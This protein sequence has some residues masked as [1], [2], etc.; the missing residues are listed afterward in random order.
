[1]TASDP[2]LEYLREK[3]SE[4][5]GQLEKVQAELKA[6]VDITLKDQYENR[7]DLL[8]K[9]I[10]KISQNI[11]SLERDHQD[12]SIKQEI[13]QLI[14][15]LQS[16]DSQWEIFQQSYHMTLLHWNSR[17]QRNVENVQSIISELSKIVQGEA[18]YNALEEFIAHLIHS[19]LDPVLVNALNQWGT[20][21]RPNIDWL[22]LYTQIQ[23][24]QDQRLEK[25]QP[26]ILMTI[27]R[28]DQ[29]STQA[30]DDETYYQLNAWLVEDIETYRSQKTGYYALLD[31]DS[32][33][34]KPCSLDNLLQKITHLLNRFLVEQRRICKYCLNYPQIHVFLPFELM[35]L[36][37]DVWPLNSE[38]GKRQKYLGHDHVVVIRCA[39][40]YDGN[41]SKGP[42]W[43][44]LWNRYQNLLQEPAQAVFVSGHDNDLDELIETL[45]EAVKSDS[46]AV[47]LQVEQ[48]PSNVEDLCYEL[49]ESGLPLAIWPR[50]NLAD[51]SH[52]VQL[53]ELLAACCLEK[54][55][56]TVK[57]KRAE[58][59][60]PKNLPASH[61]GHHL[62]LLWDDPKLTPPKSA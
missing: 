38:T 61:I 32:P 34:A 25:A 50:D 41:Y 5:Q 17:V 48:K 62:S 55:P 31:A 6:V 20:R 58:T 28:C 51:S 12:K 60:K 53:S 57:A 11:E 56:D 45:E 3:R 35:H 10:E 24:V 26:A 49:L 19:T 23:A 44:K 22:Q 43:M 59:R 39:N 30:N 15:G 46:N 27:T 33:D 9:Q 18:S 13:N 8:F 7:V 37:I 1:M 42:D 36:G 16:S 21:Y 4:C 2:K 47:G 54:L 40:R 52:T 14:A 29:A